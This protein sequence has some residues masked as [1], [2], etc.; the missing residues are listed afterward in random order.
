M[1]Y[2][3]PMFYIC[4]EQMPFAIRVEFNLFE[5]VDGTALR[6][7]VDRAMRRYPY[8]AVQLEEREGELVLVPND[9]EIVV[10]EG[11]EPAALG[12]RAFNY[13]L[14]AVSWHGREISFH[15]SH[16]FTDG[17]GCYPLFRS[18]L[19]YYF[20]ER[21]GKALDSSGF[22]LWDEPFYP[23]ELGNP[24]PEEAMAAAVPLYVPKKGNYF[25]LKD[26]G[27]VNDAQRTVYRVCLSE[28]ELLKFG[29][30]N[31]GSPCSVVS[32]L[33]TMAIWDVHPELREDI[34]SA[35][36]FNLR[37]GLGNDHSYRMLCSA[38]KIRYPE[39][40]RSADITKLCTCTRGAVTLQ[41][42]P[43]N[44]LTY[45]QNV[46]Q[47]LEALLR[48]PG[49]DEKTALLAP[50]SL[51]DATDNTFSVSYVGPAQLGEIEPFIDS[52][53]NYTDGSTYE[54]L[55]LEISNLNDEFDI[56]FLQGFSSDVYFRAFLRR[57][58]L[59]ELSYTTDGCVPPRTPGIE[60]PGG[61][62][63]FAATN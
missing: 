37:P 39:R 45:A 43:E 22:R 18:I 32:S 33:M 36:S 60:L 26:G 19:Y 59:H 61:R 40:I 4:S 12:S 50:R 52:I 62:R 42:Q 14:F 63:F 10:W 35:V 55:F 6:H 25:R 41:S 15:T 24:Y 46:R 51:E 31:D 53:Y 9:A 47:Q 23:D 57:L 27:F 8:F 38:L 20:C 21:T 29:K 13:H 49:V 17:A 11:T 1:K 56:A 54:T 2:Y 58:E 30:D 28:R 44:V 3:D 34:V 5:D 7:A 48:V 16:V